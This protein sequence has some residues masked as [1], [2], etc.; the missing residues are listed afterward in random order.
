M[1]T[2][3]PA[4]A[5]VRRA[6]RIISSLA[7]NGVRDLVIAPGG[8]SAPLA[9]AAADLRLISRHVVVDERAAGFVAIGLAR[10]TGLPVGVICTSGSAVANLHPAVVEAHAARLPLVLLTADRPAELRGTGAPQMID[11]PGIFGSAVVAAHNL[12]TPG[13]GDDPVRLDAIVAELLAA[14]AVAETGGPVHLNVPFGE[15]LWTIADVDP[16]WIQPKPRTLVPAVP[17]L[18]DGAAV[19]A[20]LAPN[21]HGV[22]VVGP[23]PR[24]DTAFAGDLLDLADRLGRPV[25]ADAASG[26]RSVGAHPRL[27]TTGEILARHERFLAEADLEVI[28]RIGGMPTT[29][30]VQEWLARTPAQIVA[31]GPD[32]A[33][34]ATTPITRLPVNP[35][36]AVRAALRADSVA[37]AAIDVRRSE[38]WRRADAA[39]RDAVTRSL[40][41]PDADGPADTPVVAALVDAAAGVPGAILHVASSMPV[42][43]VD[44]TL[45]PADG[46]V[47]T[48]NRG[49]NGIDGTIAT[50]LGQ[51]LAEPGR[52]VIALLGDLAAIHDAG[53]LLAAG[54]AGRANLTVVV[55]D[56]R[57]GGIFD[58]LPLADQMTAARFDEL[59]RTPQSH[60]DLVA[61][62]KSAGARARRIAARDDLADAVVAATAR[63]GLDVIVVPTDPAIGPAT[64]RAA[65]AEAMRAVDTVL[66]ATPGDVEVPMQS[67]G[68]PKLV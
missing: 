20:H 47:V 58:Y 49:T 37:D 15:P 3:D 27:V 19:A 57:G 55:I 5:N 14:A 4:A 25:I 44:L 61:L 21:R 8:R 13:D 12:P 67:T 62:A 48:A 9:L 53:G 40:T 42:R 45:A 2:A 17:S 46:M 1:P 41:A 35:G 60:V 52:P 34:T 32:R 31:I 28:V 43:D 26:L 65:V 63:A 54:G 51:A 50:A 22:F 36:A 64:R 56:N 29:R 11:Q 7:A 33:H 59:F 23:L 30:P 10:M 39:A 18:P 6:R 16:A 24:P 66:D 38:L 68:K